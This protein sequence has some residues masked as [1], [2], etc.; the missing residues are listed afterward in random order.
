MV[1]DPEAAKY[2]FFLRNELKEFQVSKK[3]YRRL[4]VEYVGQLKSTTTMPK[5]NF[6]AGMMQLCNPKIKVLV[7]QFNKPD[8]SKDAEE[9]KVNPSF[10]QNN[11]RLHLIP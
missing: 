9:I 11:I 2:Q 3:F 1:R 4:V 8:F 6:Q 10:Q 7:K 5:E